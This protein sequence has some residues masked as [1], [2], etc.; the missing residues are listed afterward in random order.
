MPGAEY[1]RDCAPLISILEK[2]KADGKLYGAIC[3]SPAVVLASKGLV[4]EGATCFP[5]AGLRGKMSSPVDDDVVVRVMSLLQK[6]LEL[7]CTLLSS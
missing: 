3:A 6:D 4:G 1:L 5:A 7:R 2:Q